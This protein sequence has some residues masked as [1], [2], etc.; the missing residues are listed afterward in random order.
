MQTTKKNNPEQKELSSLQITKENILDKEFSTYD[1]S[2]K[3]VMPT[4]PF[5][6]EI[7]IERWN[8]FELFRQANDK[9]KQGT[10]PNIKLVP[11]EHVDF[12]EVDKVRTYDTALGEETYVD[13]GLVAVYI[14]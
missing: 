4:N 11:K 8:R 14:G 3:S 1:V 10:W 9:S 2:E 7:D 13:R 6:K 12:V 5:N